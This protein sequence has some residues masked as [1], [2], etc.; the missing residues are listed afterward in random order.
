MLQAALQSQQRGSESRQWAAEWAGANA[1]AAVQWQPSQGSHAQTPP[2]VGR[3]GLECWLGW[4]L[5]PVFGR[6]PAR[7]A[8][9]ASNFARLPPGSYVAGTGGAGPQQACRGSTR[10]VCFRP[11]CVVCSKRAVVQP[12]VLCCW[13]PLGSNKNRECKRR[14]WPLKASGSKKV[15]HLETSRQREEQPLPPAAAQPDERT[16]LLCCC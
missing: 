4:P 11:T 12:L 10:W 3:Q 9:T 13:A 7:A 6:P 2:L 8:A 16:E 14:E 1:G 5:Q 15:F